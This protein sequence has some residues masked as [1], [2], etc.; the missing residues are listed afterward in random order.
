MSFSFAD[1]GGSVRTDLVEGFRREWDRLAQPGS[2][3][4]G[5]QRVAIAQIQRAARSG[6]PSPSV[7]MPAEVVDAAAMMAAQPAAIRR[8]WVEELVAAGLTYEEYVEIVGVVSRVAA[9]DGFHVAFGVALEPLPKP[10]PGEPSRGPAAPRARIGRAYVPM[11]GGAS[12][13]GALSLVPAESA[14][15]EDIHGPLYMTYGDMADAD[16]RRTLHRTQMELVA[17]R[18]SAANECFY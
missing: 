12:I 13:V 6:A 3:F 2:W 17:A 1:G 8:A 15:Q 14:A 4:S 16:F 18:T 7:A 10:M 5:E 11:V 9:V